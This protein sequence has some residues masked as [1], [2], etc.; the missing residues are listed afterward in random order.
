MADCYAHLSQYSDALAT[1]KTI[2]AIIPTN[3]RSRYQIMCLQRHIQDIEGA[4]Q[5]ALEIINI[6]PKVYNPKAEQYKKQAREFLEH[7]K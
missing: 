2:A 5:T 6:S 3:L 4:R 1:L 7:S